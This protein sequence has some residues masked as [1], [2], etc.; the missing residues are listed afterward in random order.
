MHEMSLAEG[1]LG[2]IENT[3]AA[4]PG[5]GR[6]EIVRSVRL[7]IGRLAAVELDALRFS[8]DVVKRGTVADGATLDVI[9]L[10]GAAWCMQ[11]CTTVTIAQRGDACPACGSYQLQVTAG[12]E[13][14]VKDIE[15]APAAMAAAG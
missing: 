9:E 6:R 5:G 2:V 4:Q 15:L 7:E 12:D 13:L 11:C 8:F 1:V 3:L 14:R 10:T